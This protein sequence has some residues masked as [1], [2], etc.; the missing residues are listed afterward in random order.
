MF[1]PDPPTVMIDGYLQPPDEV[2]YVGD[3]KSLVCTAD[4]FPTP[5]VEWDSKPDDAVNVLNDSYIKSLNVPTDHENTTTYRCIARNNAGNK[6]HTDEKEITIEV[7]GSKLY[8]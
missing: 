1:V 6:E 3:Q 7:I 5:I 2:L 8:S 4:G